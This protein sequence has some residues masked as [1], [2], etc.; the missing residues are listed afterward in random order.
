VASRLADYRLVATFNGI[1]VR[2]KAPAAD[3]SR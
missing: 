1:E 3:E 2:A